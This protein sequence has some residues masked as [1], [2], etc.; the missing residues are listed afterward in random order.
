MKEDDPKPETKPAGNKPPPRPP[1]RTAIGL[2]P[3]GDDS[4]KKRWVTITKAADGEGKFIRLSGGRGQHGHVLIKIEPN[5][6]G[7]GIEISS[8]APAGTIPEEFIKPAAEGIRE[9][10]DDGVLDG[11]PIIDVIVRIVG[12]SSDQV[13]SNDLAFKMAGVFS[14]KDAMIKAGPIGV[15]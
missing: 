6:R 15:D 1:M 9:A 11:R 7:K 8:N 4:D 14:I 12:G 2:F 13:M 5:V 10:L 3:G